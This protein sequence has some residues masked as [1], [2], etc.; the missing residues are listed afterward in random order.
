M[1]LLLLHE[2]FEVMTSMITA[3]HTRATEVEAK[4]ALEADRTTSYFLALPTLIPL[5]PLCACS[6]LNPYLGPMT[7]PVTARYGELVCRDEAAEELLLR[8]DVLS[9]LIKQ[10]YS[11]HSN[12]ALCQH[13]SWSLFIS[14]IY[15]ATL[16]AIYLSVILAARIWIKAL[17]KLFLARYPH[18]SFREDEERSALVLS[19]LMTSVKRGTTERMPVVLP[20]I[21]ELLATEDSLKYVRSSLIALASQSHL[22]FHWPVISSQ[23]TYFIAHYFPCSG[24]PLW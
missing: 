3:S 14:C 11:V 20:V 19:V 10:A 23:L 15:N 4:A 22:H 13:L 2:F 6:S 8:V 7:L 17:G 24:V 16:R 1:H 18:N 5:L 21:E 9:S 12:I